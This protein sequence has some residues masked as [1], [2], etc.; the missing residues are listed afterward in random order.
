M[1]P[2]V[3][4][5]V[6][7]YNDERYV[8][9]CLDSLINQLLEEIEIIVVDDGST[10]NSKVICEQFVSL[11][12]RVKL[13]CKENGGLSDARNTGLKYAN[14]GYVGF[15]DSDDYV[16][17]DFYKILYEGIQSKD[18]QLAV[19]QIKKTDDVGNVLFC[20]G[21]DQERVISNEEAM[22]SM[23][24][25]KGISNSVCNKLFRKDLF[26]ENPFPVGKLYED[27]YV[28]Y[29][30]VD[31][32]PKVFYTNS[33]AYY[34]RTNQTGITHHS[35]SEK[36]VDRIEASLI[37]IDYLTEKHPNLVDD[38]KRYLMYDCLTALSKMQKYESQYN[39]LFTK[40]I[41]ACLYV[42]LCGKSSIGAKGFAILAAIS[43]KYALV[44]FRIVK[45]LM[46]GGG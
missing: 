29:R 18:V 43:P 11:D 5:I 25:V 31:M 17:D 16:D 26:S 46:K 1:K 13:V 4:I 44:L 35:F 23:L 12:D 28:A 32:C 37:R 3:S 20:A 21:Y 41:R 6:P 24:S 9:Q 19:A 33:A 7:V 8:K 45:K 2:L 30:I 15:I 27:E 22:Q 39:K 14:A 42:Y 40:N 34:Y 36:E 38:G 10:D